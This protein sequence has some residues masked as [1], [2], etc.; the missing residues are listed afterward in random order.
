MNCTDAAAAAQIQ[1]MDYAK[2]LEFKENKVKN[3]L[4]RLG[5]FHADFVD[6]VTEPIVGMENPYRLPQ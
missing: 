3:N 6:S 2:Q 5:G 1:A 4:I